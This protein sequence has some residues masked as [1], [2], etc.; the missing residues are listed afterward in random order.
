MIVEDVHKVYLRFLYGGQYEKLTDLYQYENIR[1]NLKGA[2]SGLDLSK[3]N[4]YKIMDEVR[5]LNNCIKHSK[6]A[7]GKLAGSHRIWKEGE[8]ITAENVEIR[9]REYE[10]EMPKYLDSLRSELNRCFDEEKM[11]DYA[12]KVAGKKRKSNN[13]TRTAILLAKAPVLWGGYRMLRSFANR[14]RI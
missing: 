2:C 14:R 10:A 1:R 3:V 4:A 5:N 13:S 8:K 12:R 7:S 9:I 11:N 6:I